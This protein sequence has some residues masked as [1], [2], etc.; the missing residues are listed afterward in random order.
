[1]KIGAMFAGFVKDALEGWN[2]PC[3]KAAIKLLCM[4]AA[5]ESGGFKYVKQIKGPA[6]GLFQMEPA[7]HADVVAYMQRKP[8]RFGLLAQT[9]DFV[10]A[11]VFD[12]GYAAALARI[13]FLRIPEPLPDADDVDALARYAKKYWNTELGK[14]TWE[15]YA[16]AY[17]EYFA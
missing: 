2:L 13:F 11:M 3:S 10:D 1:M 17:R 14:A 4:I 7:T 6:L 15:D 5:H 16:S 12:A 9:S 8:E